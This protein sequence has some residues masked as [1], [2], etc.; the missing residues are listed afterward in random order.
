MTRGAGSNP[1]EAVTADVVLRLLAGLE[2]E[3][4]AQSF[5]STCGELLGPCRTRLFMYPASSPDDYDRLELFGG[6]HETKTFKAPLLGPEGLIGSSVAAIEEEPAGTAV[7]WRAL[8]PISQDETPLGV[9]QVSFA[10]P[11]EASAVAVLRELV[12]V[13]GV[14]FH[15]SQT[16]EKTKRLTFTDDLTALYNARFMA[17]YLDRELK[18]CRRTR[19]SLS[20]L[21]MDLD[22]FKAVNDTHGH[23]AGSRTL[24]EVGAVL[25][26]TVRDADVLI[27]YGGDEFVILFP[28][29]PLSGGLIIAERIRQVIE[30]TKF[31]ETHQ[32]EARV[33]ASIGIA[34]YPESAD[35]VRG[36]ISCADQAMYEAKALGKNRVVT[37]KPFRPSESS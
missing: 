6:D 28:E 21:F 26:K 37:A 19:A 36:L 20:L 8:L 12:R 30:S 1:P 33:S 27:R 15:N 2:P 24:V 31:L 9:A 17:L 16:F 14:A 29:T 4:V 22:G 25:E 5:A 3:A 7:G 11:I 35:D 34:A 32:L 23:L 10:A 18:R 13:L